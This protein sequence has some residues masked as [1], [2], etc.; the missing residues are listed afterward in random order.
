MGTTAQ[1]IS[2]GRLWT[3]VLWTLVCLT[4]MTLSGFPK[5]ALMDPGKCESFCLSSGFQGSV[6]NCNCGYI[7]FSK[8]SAPIHHYPEDF[9]EDEL[10][11][12]HDHHY[13]DPILA[14]LSDD[15]I[16]DALELLDKIKHNQHHNKQLSDRELA[17]LLWLVTTIE[18]PFKI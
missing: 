3:W 5:R 16:I 17:L 18:T 14:E 11:T 7:M 13:E 1:H 8:R 4:K 15:E 12:K 6:G 9:I 2:R 10:L